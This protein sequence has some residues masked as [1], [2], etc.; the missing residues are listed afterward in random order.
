MPFGEMV[1]RPMQHAGHI[2]VLMLS[3]A[4]RCSQTSCISCT[5]LPEHTLILRFT[6]LRVSRGD[7]QTLTI[8]PLGKP[9]AFSYI[10]TNGHASPSYTS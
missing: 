2:E 5:L 8:C 3:Q 10:C 7:L 1:S 6:H 9:L 4:K